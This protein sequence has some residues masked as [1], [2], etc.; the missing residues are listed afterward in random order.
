[1]ITLNDAVTWK[2][3]KLSANLA[4]CRKLIIFGVTAGR[5]IVERSIAAFDN[6]VASEGA[7]FD[8]V[9]SESV[10]A[11]A[12]ALEDYLRRQYA[13]TGQVLVKR[14]FS[15]GYGD[16]ALT[17]QKDIFNILPMDKI[18]V[19]LSPELIMAPEKSITA[20]IGIINPGD[21]KDNE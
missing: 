19:K 13:R 14:R 21:A 7:I 16:W 2:S 6:A 11:A 4:D 1:M 10:E 18:G 3:E 12:D 17:A 5:E 9:G 20:V 15:P 8:A